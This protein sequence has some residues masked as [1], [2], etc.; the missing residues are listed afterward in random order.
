MRI[1]NTIFTAQTVVLLLTALFFLNGNLSAQQ[2]GTFVDKRDGNSYKWVKAGNQMWMVDNLRFA[3]PNGSWAVHDD[4]ANIKTYGRLYDWGTATKACPKGWHLPS[5][6]EW[7]VLVKNLGGEDVAGEKF[8][9]MDT[10][11]VPQDPRSAMVSQG[12]SRLLSGVRHN[13][14]AF[15]GFG[16]WGGCW[17]ATPAGTDAANNWLF[18]KGS[19]SIRKSSSTK[20]SAYTVRCVKK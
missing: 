13:D 6:A 4:T 5:D 12:F 3:T 7:N 1:K 2:K 20:N 16:V 19:Q 17:S 8:Q 11:K 9:Q 10:V 18:A 14:G 15:D